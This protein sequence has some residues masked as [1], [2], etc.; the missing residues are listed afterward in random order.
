MTPSTPICPRVAGAQVGTG[1]RGSLALW[2][3]SECRLDLRPPAPRPAGGPTAGIAGSHE[4]AEPTCGWSGT[5]G[6]G[7]RAQFPPCTEL[8]EHPWLLPPS[9]GSLLCSEWRRSWFSR[10]V[11][12]CPCRLGWAQL[13]SAGPQASLATGTQDSWGGVCVIFHFSVLV[14]KVAYIKFGVCVWTFL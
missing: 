8:C 9:W 1:V 14:F 12:A 7:R 10:P 2:T 13:G 3:D 5:A 6:R 11:G 4:E